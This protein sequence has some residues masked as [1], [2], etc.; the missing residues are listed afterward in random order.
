MLAEKEGNEAIIKPI[1]INS[2][3]EKHTSGLQ[4]SQ[5]LHIQQL[6]SNFIIEHVWTIF[7]LFRIW[8]YQQ[9]H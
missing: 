5:F 6:V 3:A 2:F 7:N 8:K 4:K 9:A 1:S